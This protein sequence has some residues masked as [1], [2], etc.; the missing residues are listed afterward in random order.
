MDDCRSS[1][2][3]RRRPPSSRRGDKDEGGSVSICRSR[4]RSPSCRRHLIDE[5]VPFISR[6]ANSQNKVNEADFAAND[7]FHVS[8]EHMSRSVWA[9]APE[10]TQRMSEMVLRA[11][12]GP[13]RRRPRPPGHPRAKEPVPNRVSHPR[14]SSRRPTSRSSSTLGNSFPIWSHGAP[15]RTS[16]SSQSVEAGSEAAVDEED[17][18]DIVARAILFRSTEKLVTGLGLVGYRRQCRRV[19]NRLPGPRDSLPAST[20]RRSGCVR[21]PPGRDRRCA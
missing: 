11:R 12:S 8:V 1:T 10:G 20:W 19:F 14:R 3:A 15:R 21:K 7:P 5:F 2:V 13:I 17:S 18:S 4:Q 16:A 6:Y 9:P